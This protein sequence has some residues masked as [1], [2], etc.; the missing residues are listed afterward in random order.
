MKGKNS[1]MA[2]G[3]AKGT[4]GEGEKKRVF[5]T[6]SWAARKGEEENRR[7]QGRPD[8][9]LGCGF[10]RRHTLTTTG[11]A[12]D[13]PGGGGKGSLKE[14]WGQGGQGGRGYNRKTY[15][16]LSLIQGWMAIKGGGRKESELK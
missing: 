12:T 1:T 5:M 16:S 9:D 2:R 7:S 11:V 3:I 4:L 13:L 10:S 15:P 8:E 14:G 6:W